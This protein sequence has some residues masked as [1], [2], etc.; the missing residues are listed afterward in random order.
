MGNGREKYMRRVLKSAIASAAMAAAIGFATP[1]LAGV[2]VVQQTGP[3]LDTKIY[4]AHNGAATVG[5]TV[6]GSTVKDKVTSDV[7]F[8]GFN[9]YNFATDTGTGVTI[10]ITDGGGFAQVADHDFVQQGNPSDPIPT[11]D[12]LLYLLFNPT[13]TFY[14]YEFSIQTL[15]GGQTI[16]I[17]Y[18][19][20]GG[21]WLVA[22]GS[23]I[24]NGNGDTQYKVGDPNDP[25]L[26]IDK[27]MIG[28]AS[29]IE[30]VKQNSI[31]LTGDT[32]LPEPGTWGLMLLGFG[33]IGMIMRR[34]RRRNATLMQIA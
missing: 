5:T 2:T 26:Q 12:N 8:S 21:G 25:T 33:G 30:H 15:A 17:W 7:A 14:Y 20:V 31:Q 19:L 27:I 32:A 4:A 23:P 22:S 3:D 24:I 34:S 29:P 11:Q 18:E 9:T 28:S 10:D 16:N 6:F 13:P 1:A